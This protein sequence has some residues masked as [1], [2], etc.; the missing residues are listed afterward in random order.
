MNESIGS[1]EECSPLDFGAFF[2][3]SWVNYLE[4]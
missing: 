3:S 1:G 4:L 2:R